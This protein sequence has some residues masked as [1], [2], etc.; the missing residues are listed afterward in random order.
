MDKINFKLKRNLFLLGMVILLFSLSFKIPEINKD[1][2]LKIL[3]INGK[4]VFKNEDP[5]NYYSFNFR[6]A[7]SMDVYL[8]EKVI[9]LKDIKDLKE[10]ISNEQIVLFIRSKDV[11]RNN[12]LVEILDDMHLVWHSNKYTLYT[13]K[14][15]E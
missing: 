3:A 13:N 6:S 1:L 9:N 8:G 15:G 10:I 2:G 11:K 4:E 12:N 7:S 14:K 5:E